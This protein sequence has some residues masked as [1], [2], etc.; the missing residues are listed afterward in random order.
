[1]LRAGNFILT[2]SKVLT[3]QQA[4]KYVKREKI[5]EEDFFCRDLARNAHIHTFYNC[6]G[7]AVSS[8]LCKL[9]CLALHNRLNVFTD[10][11]KVIPL[12]QIIFGFRKGSRTRTIF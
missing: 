8:I 11:N 12:N 7:I 1:M 5:F 3:F 4:K 6:R 2:Y 10:R 9:F